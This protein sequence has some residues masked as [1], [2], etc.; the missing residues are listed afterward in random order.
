MLEVSGVQVRFEAVA[1]LDGVDLSVPTGSVTALMGPSGC[2]K[3]TL[4]RVVAGLQAPD[5]G[6]VTWRGRSLEGIA[7]HDRGFG[8][9]FQD[10]ALFPHR[11]VGENVGFG[12]RMTGADKDV[13][14]RRTGEVLAM[15][16]L[17]GFER[18]PIRGLSGGEQQRVALARALAPAPEL[19]MLDEPLG[20]LDRALRDRLLADVRLLFDELGLTVVYVTHDPFE[21]FAVADRVAVMRDG[22]I[23][24]AAPPVD[25]WH[26]PG[27]RRVA[28]LIGLDNVLTAE[29][30][31]LLAGAGLALGPDA[32]ASPHVAL[33][34]D[35][36]R[37]D[38][39][40]AANAVVRAGTFDAGRYRVAVDVAGIELVVIASRLPIPGARVSIRVDPRGVVRLED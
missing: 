7:P 19:L 26:D 18:R 10:F 15:V 9:M 12:P 38:A 32:L 27:S 4:L 39:S 3:S 25:L 30:A 13:V 1:A 35:T 33:P 22:R 37:L 40:S 17:V 8:L 6:E 21:A 16:G 20:S 34:A 5:A 31:S 2:G 11:T 23:L 29:Q 28:E 36:L 24:A 14:A